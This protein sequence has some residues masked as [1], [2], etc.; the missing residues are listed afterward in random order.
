M[1]QLSPKN[2]LH[3]RAPYHKH[4][5]Q[6]HTFSTPPEADNSEPG[7]KQAAMLY[8]HLGAGMKILYLLRASRART[9]C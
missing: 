1:I 5:V 9:N 2:D 8:E 6:A 4:S 7:L 3:I